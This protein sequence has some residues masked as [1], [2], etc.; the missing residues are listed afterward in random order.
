MIETQQILNSDEMKLLASLVGQKWI[1]IS[2]DGLTD[3]NF[4]W[5]GIRIETEMSAIEIALEMSA[6]DI[7]GVI[8]DYPCLHVAT[9]NAISPSATKNGKIYFQGKNEIV[10]EVWILRETIRG[11]RN[12]QPEFKNTADI[13]IAILLG[14]TWTAFARADHFTDAFDICRSHSRET[15]DLPNSLDEWEENLMDRFDLEREWIQVG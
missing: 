11:S 1:N 7:D 13:L 3:E 2:S 5:S 12:N 9:R 6:L 10:K 8:D 4:S 15:L 14:S